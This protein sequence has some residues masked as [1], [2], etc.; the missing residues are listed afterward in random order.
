MQASKLL[1]A[2]ALMGLTACSG[3]GGGN[4]ST[5]PYGGGNTTGTTTTDQ[6]PAPT[7]PNTVNANPG[8]AYNPTSLTIARGGTVTFNF[9]SVGHS[10]TFTTSGAPA[11]IPVT[12]NAAVQ[13]VF[14]STGTFNYY[15]TVHAYMSGSIIV[16]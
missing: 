12:A 11:N 16:Q 4:S 1:M 9:G 7:S 10:V 8:L 6:N 2:A 13:V 5:S 15:C 14:P 3:G